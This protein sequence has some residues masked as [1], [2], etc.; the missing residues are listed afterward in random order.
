MLISEARLSL[1]LIEFAILDRMDLQVQLTKSKDS[2]LQG[3]R[4]CSFLSSLYESHCYT[5]GRWLERSSLKT[6]KLQNDQ[7]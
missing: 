4:P 1:N 3:I 6:I 2:L 7:V 5:E